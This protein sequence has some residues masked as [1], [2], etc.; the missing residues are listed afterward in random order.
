MQTCNLFV[1]GKSSLPTDWD[2]LKFVFF[3]L[4]YLSNPNFIA[5]C[6]LKTTPCLFSIRR[7]LLCAFSVSKLYTVYMSFGA[8]WQAG[9]R[10]PPMRLRPNNKKFS[11]GCRCL[12]YAVDRAFFLCME[13]GFLI[14]FFFPPFLFFFF[15]LF[16]LFIAGWTCKV[17]GFI[18]RE[19]WFHRTRGLRM[20]SFCL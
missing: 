11:T 2:H 6:P 10:G 16:F 1:N 19:C 17:W 7:E 4:P 3:S 15:F 14:F 9:L 8:C 13:N 12:N 5:C 18:R 20:S